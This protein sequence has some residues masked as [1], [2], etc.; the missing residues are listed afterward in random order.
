[1]F[2]RRARSIFKKRQPPGTNSH[3]FIAAKANAYYNILDTDYDNYAVIFSCNNYYG[4]GNVSFCLKKFKIDHPT[5]SG[6]ERKERVGAC[7]AQRAR[8]AVRGSSDGGPRSELSQP[9]V[10]DA[11]RA[12]LCA[13]NALLTHNHQ[14]C[15]KPVI[16][17]T[18][19]SSAKCKGWLRPNYDNLALT[20]CLFVPKINARTKR[21]NKNVFVIAD[22]CNRSVVK[23]L[24]VEVEQ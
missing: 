14:A 8:T 17:F 4:I 11:H 5:P 3:I 16:S 24:Q 20:H 19:F 18:F 1:M 21:P 10:P 9:D 6:S 2:F 22:T 23:L 12:E 13:A 15:H 7:P